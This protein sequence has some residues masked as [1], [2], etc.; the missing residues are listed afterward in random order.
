MSVLL[1]LPRQAPASRRHRRSSRCVAATSPT[2]MPIEQASYPKPWTIGVFHSETRDD[3]PRRAH[4]LVARD[5]QRR[6]SATAG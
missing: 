3:A 2:I 6:S 4:Y 5:G 1:A